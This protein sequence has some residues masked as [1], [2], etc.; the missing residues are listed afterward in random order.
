MVAVVGL[1]TEGERQ[2]TFSPVND[3]TSGTMLWL[4]LPVLA[5]SL[6]VGAFSS[7][8]SLPPLG[9]SGVGS[10]AESR[11][12]SGGGGLACYDH[13][14]PLLL[15]QVAT[16]SLSGRSAV[17]SVLADA[18]AR[19]VAAGGATDSPPSSSLSSS[20]TTFP[21]ASGSAQG[22]LWFLPAALAPWRATTAAG[23]GSG[24]GGS[25]EA[26]GGAGNHLGNLAEESGGG[27]DRGSGAG[28][29][30]AGGRCGTSGAVAR[31]GGGGKCGWPMQREA[32]GL[33]G[34]AV[35]PETHAVYAATW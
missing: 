34:F 4:Q 1:V 32:S 3:P 30:A 12:E 26:G 28:V 20:A 13:G 14:G 19:A 35:M 22:P 15:E 27:V 7:S 25:S 18:Q 24:A 21:G 16:V 11:A 29:D 23:T 31:G 9:G 10:G 33:G 8:E 2:A 17:R 5:E 6:G